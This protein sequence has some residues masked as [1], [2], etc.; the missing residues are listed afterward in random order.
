MTQTVFITGA[1]GGIGRALCQVF[2]ENGYCVIAS[3]RISANDLVCDSFVK[4]DL[5]QFCQASG[6]R[7]QVMHDIR[8]VLNGRGLNALINNAAIQIVKPTEAL[9]VEDW[10]T[11]FDVNLLAPFLLIQQLLP[12]LESASGSVVNIASIHAQLTKPEF[13]CYATSK[14]ALV[15]LTKSLAVDLGPRIRVNAICPAA[16][17]TPMLVAGL[18][19][20]K[21]ALDE[22]ASMHPINRIA[23]PDEIAKSAIFL[24]SNSSSFMTGETINLY[25][26]IGGRL[27]D[28]V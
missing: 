6:Y 14:A 11:T 21:K 1:V 23:K 2:K 25:G 27:H 3:D 7:D 22:L 20:K 15:G 4:A 9:T 10:H 24:T 19:G 8:H 5:E 17:E 13:A 16:V 26:G 18:E 28:P 12:E